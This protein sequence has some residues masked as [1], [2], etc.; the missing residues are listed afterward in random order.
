MNGES[1]SAGDLTAGSVSIAV[2]N[3]GAEVHEIGM[4][5]LVD[6]HT[7][8][9]VRAALEA[10]GEDEDPLEGLVEEGSVIAADRG[11]SPLSITEIPQVI[12]GVVDLECR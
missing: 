10:A 4:A 11:F 12:G 7:V 1:T 9:E 3:L 6:G 8:E 2:E 5:K